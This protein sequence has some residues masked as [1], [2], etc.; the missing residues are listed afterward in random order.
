VARCHS[1][2]L[3]FIFYSIH[4]FIQSL[5][6]NTFAEASLHLL[7][8]GK[9]SGKTSLWCRAENQT[10]FQQADALPTEPRRT[11]N[12]VRLGSDGAMRNKDG[13]INIFFVQVGHL[14]L[15]LNSAGNLL[16]YLL[17]GYL[18]T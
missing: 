11:I 9:L 18:N 8:A 5:S 17:A 2:C 13:F 10:A 3:F 16:I 14:A 15:S 4:T 12:M 6:Y 7:I 1:F